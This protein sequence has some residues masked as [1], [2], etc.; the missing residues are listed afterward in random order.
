[1][2]SVRDS[3]LAVNRRS[4]NTRCPYR[5]SIV[6]LTSRT[7][8]SGATT[9]LSSMDGAMCS[10]VG[11]IMDLI[12]FNLFHLASPQREVRRRCHRATVAGFW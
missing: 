5:R 9:A 11:Y 10:C 4:D 3:L 6:S 2:T 8:T 1:M 12:V 7:L